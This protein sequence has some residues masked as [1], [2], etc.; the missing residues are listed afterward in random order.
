ME[1]K[2]G[3]PETFRKGG[4]YLSRGLMGD[5]NFTMGR[6]SFPGIIFSWDY[7]LLDVSKTRM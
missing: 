1:L 3:I 2:Y 7:L 6:S 4:A 5:L